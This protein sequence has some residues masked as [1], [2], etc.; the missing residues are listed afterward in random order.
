VSGILKLKNKP[1]LK[2]FNGI[3]KED[4]KE[5]YD[6]VTYFVRYLEKHVILDLK[7]LEDHLLNKGFMK[8]VILGDSRLLLINAE[9]L[10]NECSRLLDQ[11]IYY[12]LKEQPLGLFDDA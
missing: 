12:F 3:I 7:R 2:K 11:D 9:D 5:Y 8:E 1:Y 10:F 4:N 6:E